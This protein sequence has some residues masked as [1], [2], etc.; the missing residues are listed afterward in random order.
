MVFSSPLF[1]FAF[2]PYALFIC[3]ATPRSWRNAVL[4]TLSLVFY[5]WGECEYSW[6]LL[7][8][9]AGNYVAGLAVAAALVTAAVIR[10]V[11]PV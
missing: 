2:L 7:A 10:L 6:V 3:F 8:S 1:L 9:V 4:L 11:A 5:V